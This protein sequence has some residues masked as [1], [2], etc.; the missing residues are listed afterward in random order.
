VQFLQINST[1]LNSFRILSF[2]NFKVLHY[3]SKVL[4]FFV[5]YVYW[6][7]KN[8]L[9]SVSTQQT[10]I[11]IFDWFATTHLNYLK[12][13]RLESRFLGKAINVN[14]TRIFNVK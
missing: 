4:K 8:F 6:G 10:E 12:F 1:K 11:S 2:L 3:H 9:E 5:N 13:V 7:S 14:K